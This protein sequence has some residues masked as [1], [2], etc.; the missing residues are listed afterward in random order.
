HNDFHLVIAAGLAA[1][2]YGCAGLN[3]TLL[4]FGE[5]TGNPPIEGACIHYAGLTGSTNGMDLS[6]ITEI[7]HY[8]QEVIR[9]RIP[10]NTPFVGRD[11]NVTRA[12]IHADGAIKNEEIYN[13]FDT[14]AILNR[15]PTVSVT[16]K[17]GIS[18]ILYW[19]QTQTDLDTG[20]LNKA[21]P[22]V[23]NI[24]D[25][26]DTQYQEGR[27]TSISPDEMHHQIRKHLPHLFKSEFDHIK[28]RV[29]SIA[30]RIV[31]GLAADGA[32]RSMDPSRQVPVLEQ[33]LEAEPFI[34]YLY[35]TDIRGKKITPNV[36]HPYSRA[37]YD[38]E[39]IDHQDFADRSW[40][41]NPIRDGKTHLTDF[42]ISRFDGKL[43]IT[44]S[45]PI[46]DDREEI[47]GILGADIQFEDAA[48]LE[49]EDV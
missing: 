15:P 44:V 43:C 3:A 26:I 22:G 41:I 42:Y 32:I 21:H 34:K 35:I 39:F 29:R 1:W 36:T 6:V 33:C 2:L 20:K 5:R 25:W 9:F 19:I 47:V 46:R 4:G 8:Y 37:A 12:G 48:K 17:S 7:A 10:P 24:R 31:E 13:I 38:R 23:V 16:D 40:F 11:F 14:K 27:T 45:T 49:D 30:S 28:E 18:G